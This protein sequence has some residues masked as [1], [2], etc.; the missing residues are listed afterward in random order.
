MTCA[1]CFCG[2][3]GGSADTAPAGNEN[4]NAAAA[5]ATDPASDDPTASRAENGQPNE[6]NSSTAA[7][8]AGAAHRRDE[9]WTDADGNRYLGNVPYDVFAVHPYEIAADMTPVNGGSPGTA[10]PGGGGSAAGATDVTATGAASGTIPAANPA[11]ES[12]GAQPAPGS[13]G[14][15]SLISRDVLEAEVK[16]IRNFMTPT[17]QSVGNFRSSMAMIPPKAATLAVLAEVASQHPEKVSWHDDAG[18]LRDLARQMNESPLQP[19]ASDQRRLRD[20]FA[21]IADTLNRSR[22]AGLSEPPAGQTFSDVAEMRLVMKRMEDANRRLTTEVSSEASLGLQQDMIQH[23]AE[24]L[25]TLTKVVTTDG[26]GYADDSD[27]KAH[28]QRIIDAASSITAATSATNF[29][30]YQL[31]LTQIS[32]ACQ[33]CHSDYKNN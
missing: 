2:G 25:R 12:T 29:S 5:A 8:A 20:L 28:A 31:A 16:D 6:R 24:L 32:S 13:S 15:D 10:V 14:W 33:A 1:V 21:A 23:E 19:G 26:Y 27:F 17:L 7:H 4:G 3:C 9:V 11:T 30:D 18:Y 22:P